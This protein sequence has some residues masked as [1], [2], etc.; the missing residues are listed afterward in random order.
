MYDSFLFTACENDEQKSDNGKIDAVQNIEFNIDFADYNDMQE[1][2]VTRSADNATQET[3]L[4]QQMTKAGNGIVAK[5]T[6]QRDTTQKGKSPDTRALADDTYTMLTYDAATHAFKGEMSGKIVGGV[7]TVTSSNELIGL[8]AGKTYDFVL[9][10]SK[11]TRNGNL[12]TVTRANAADALI[13]RTTKTLSAT[14]RKQKVGFTMKHTGAKIKLKL[15]GY[16]PFSGVAAVLSS[17]SSTDIPA[18]SVYDAATGTWSAG[19]G[20]AFSSP[21]ARCLCSRSRRWHKHRHICCFE[22]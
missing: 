18:S 11:V 9:F 3:K 16:M 6:L 5:A 2:D 20:T 4:Q 22:Q 21:V 10:N 1:I 7:F 19:T 12:L 8:A 13:R 14:P 15:T 17:V